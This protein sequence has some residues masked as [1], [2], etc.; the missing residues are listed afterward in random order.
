MNEQNTP[1][2]NWDEVRT[3]YA[4][5]RLGTLSAAAIF[6][7]VHHATVIRHIDALEARLGGKLFQRHP[8]G[9]TPTEAGRDL[10]AVA[11]ATEDQFA[12]FAARLRGVS[13][14][15]SGELIITTVSGF[16]TWLTP[17]LAKFQ[18][19]HP[20]LRLSLVLDTRLLRLEYGEAH[21]AVRA[22]PKPQEPDNVV[23]H[24]GRF[25]LSLF[26]HKDY[27]AR[28]GLLA[29]LSQL[30]GHRFVGGM[31]SGATSP[32][33]RWINTHV[34]DSDIVF[35]ASENNAQTHAIAAGVGIGF[36]AFADLQNHDLV[37]MCPPLPEW[38]IDIWLV[39]HMA[40][41]RTAKVQALS[42]FLIDQARGL[43]GKARP[44]P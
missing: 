20:D 39:S 18:Q 15:V 27:V 16:S 43:S 21:L 5:A 40:L 34:A 37:Q 4:V 24:F 6:L 33:D 44:R 13:A 12:Q 26:A 2:A 1:F 3:A 31:K 22:G 25:S 8:R 41:H 29:D 9:Y 35:R 14:E 17:Y 38:D 11:S 30:K 23:Q 7:G 10:L 28:H 32:H 19:I 42:H 36:A